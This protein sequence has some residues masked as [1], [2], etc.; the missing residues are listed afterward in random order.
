MLLFTALATIGGSSG[1]GYR[2]VAAVSAVL[3]L[4]GGVI[5]LFYNEAKLNHVI[6]EP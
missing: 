2:V 1:T 4:S 3:A 6:Q 5:L